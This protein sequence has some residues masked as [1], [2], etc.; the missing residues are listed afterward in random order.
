MA[1]DF[2]RLSDER[3]SGNLA[4]LDELRHAHSVLLGAI[5]ELAELTKGPLPSR[6]VLNR[7]RWKL[8]R[9][10]LSRRMLWTRILCEISPNADE[11]AKGDLQLLQQIDMQLLRDSTEHVTRWATDDI[12]DDWPGYGRASEKMR[13]KMME[14]VAAEQRL[15]YPLFEAPSGN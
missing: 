9:A 12:V 13:S 8:S 10:S 7:V 6:E 3:R 15:L 11:R 1:A 2:K 14:A 4:M 5:E